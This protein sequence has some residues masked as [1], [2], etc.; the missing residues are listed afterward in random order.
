MT[1]GWTKWGIEGTY[2]NSAE[3]GFLLYPPERRPNLFPFKQQIMAKHEASFYGTL[4]EIKNFHGTSGVF[5]PDAMA[6]DYL[7][8]DLPDPYGRLEW[9]AGLQLYRAAARLFRRWLAEGRFAPDYE[10]SRAAGRIGWKPVPD[11]AGAA[12]WQRLVEEATKLHSD[13]IPWDGGVPSALGHWFS[14]AV[15]GMADSHP[16]VA[17]AWGQLAAGHALL[18]LGLGS[19]GGHS[20]EGGEMPVMDEEDWLIA[21][22]WKQDD[23]PYRVVLQLAEPD[24]E[25]AMWRLRTVLQDKAAPEEPPYVWDPDTGGGRRT[26]PEGWNEHAPRRVDKEQRKWLN[27]VPFL[28]DPAQPGQVRRT[29]DD[30][31]AWEFLTES[32]LRLA[33]AGALLLLP[34]WWDTV[35]RNKLRLQAKVRSSVGGAGSGLFGVEQLI[36]FDWRVAVG[37][38]NLS[39]EEFRRLADQG[40]RLNQVNGQWVLLDPK[41]LEELRRVMKRIRKNKGLSF[42]E[43]LELHLLG[44]EELLSGD[45]AD[46]AEGDGAL[47]EPEATLRLEVELNDHLSEL[48]GQLQHTKKL[49][50]LDAPTGLQGELRRYQQEGYSWLSFLQPFGLG[51][52]LADD[53]GL[54]KT[55]QWISYLLQAQQSGLLDGPALLICPTSVIG[56]WQMELQRFSPGLRVA[57]HYGS[58]R[59]R[60][61]GFAAY[62]A[63]ADLVITSYTLAHLDEEELGSL[64]WSALCLDEAQNIKNVYT[65]QA[66]SIRKLQARHR[67]ALTGT[68]IENRLTELWSIFDFVN[69]GYLGS[70][71]EF[72]RAYATPVERGDQ[73][74][75][76]QLQQ[77]VRPFLLRR[78]K[79]DPAIQLDLPEKN[80][81]K[82]YVPL[83]AEQ[84][85]LY[86]SIVADL[87]AKIDSLSMM[88]RRGLI[89]AT[90]TKLKQV[91]DHP[92]LLKQGAHHASGAGSAKLERLLEMIAEVREEG[93]KC[94][95]FTQFVEMG[96]LLKEALER[97]LKEPVQFLHGGVP[98]HKR[99]EMV[100]R[101]QDPAG[102]EG[103]P[104]IFLLSL[105]AGGT[106]LNLT[107]ANHVFHFDRWWN[108]AVE[109]QATDRAFRIGQTRDVQVHKFITLGTLEERIDQMIE[110]KQGLSQQIIGSGENWI[111]ELSTS[112]LRELFALRRQWLQD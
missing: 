26:W 56:N 47:R 106:G 82:T 46:G 63:D 33:E 107:A 28:E 86:E 89:L 92:L 24:G 25:H 5:L 101:F 68:P 18:N 71:S 41:L 23:A 112:E 111:T 102:A 110:K 7:G 10:R 29:L 96:H 6:L 43:L 70:L 73:E 44:G 36:A 55:I 81:M 9:S 35:R 104:S 34:A 32:S 52:C 66:A 87:L 21:I 27:A 50:V 74:K 105:K 99:D 80:E 11:E 15:N 49:P 100:A 3:S 79:K 83:T 84:G 19:G 37:D 85:A 88:E 64:E 91:C 95:V 22:G 93:E 2:V 109:N 62:A 108:P 30:A 1:Q 57:V 12:E 13:P 90:L 45:G 98:K 72:R 94:L 42:R 51:G 77:L 53:M 17:Q 16:E 97:E 69:P 67:V 65:K 61:E 38:L 75:A 58:R 103:S 31:E 8:K 4:L 60:G 76:A 54:G 14:G 48:A 40:N 39:E 78:V 59:T 20:Q